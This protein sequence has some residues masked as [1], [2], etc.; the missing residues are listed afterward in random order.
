MSKGGNGSATSRSATGPAFRGSGGSRAVNSHMPR[1]GLLGGE[2]GAL[3][4][5]S[6]GLTALVDGADSFIFVAFVVRGRVKRERAMACSYWRVEIV[7][8]F[9]GLSVSREKKGRGD[10]TASG[11]PREPTGGE[12]NLPFFR[13]AK[14]RETGGHSAA[15]TSGRSSHYESRKWGLIGEKNVCV[16]KERRRT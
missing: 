1:A 4:K 15:L 8:S 10:Q 11:S 7:F 3:L 2:R 9:G 16:R 6:R 13:K 5:E 14:G 12:K